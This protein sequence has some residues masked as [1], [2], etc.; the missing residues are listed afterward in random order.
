MPNLSSPART[1]ATG[2][3]RSSKFQLLEYIPLNKASIFPRSSSRFNQFHDQLVLTSSSDS[4]VI[5][6]CLASISSEPH[7]YIMDEDDDVDDEEEK[8]GESTSSKPVLDDGVI[9]TF[10]DH[11]ES[12]Y[13]AA[14]S[15]ADPWT[16]ASLSYDGR[17]VVNTVPRAVK[18][19]ILNLT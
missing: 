16:F 8:V 9:K 3:G 10:E 19:K 1:T 17:L 4:K 13:S 18:F 15:A 11:E 2:S 7:G 6:S 5:L 12:V 14:W